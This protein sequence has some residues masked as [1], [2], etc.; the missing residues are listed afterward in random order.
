MIVKSLEQVEKL[1]YYI[2]IYSEEI[3]ISSYPSC[4]NSEKLDDI[5]LQTTLPI[6]LV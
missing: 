5:T 4:Y 6:Q 2:L 3:D 1:N